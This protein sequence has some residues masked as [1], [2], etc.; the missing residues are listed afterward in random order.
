[1][2]GRNPQ[3]ASESMMVLNRLLIL[4]QYS[5]ASYL[6]YASPWTQQG[7]GQM[8]EAVRQI[9]ANHE[10]HVDRIGRLIRERRG[11]IDRGEFPT[12]FTAYNYLALDYLALR[13]VEH[14]RKLIEEIAR[15][16]DE[17]GTD[18]EALQL[19]QSLLASERQN[20]RTLTELFSPH[21]L[22]ATPHS[23]AALVA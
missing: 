14:E 13:L 2:N 19:G 5:L 8:L 20:L 15:C 12:Q 9:T 1:M 6:R 18:P 7:N 23:V 10:A 21:T 11:K 16:V 3:Q 4:I 22:R 17:L